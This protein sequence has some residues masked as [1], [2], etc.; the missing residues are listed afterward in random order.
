MT[1]SQGSCSRTSY[2]G[3]NFSPTPDAVLSFKLLHYLSKAPGSFSQTMWTHAAIKPNCL[4]I[5]P[6][7]IVPISYDADD[8]HDGDD[9]VDII[10][11]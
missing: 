6:L 4:T 2:T 9:E 3:F 11:E 10:K 5:S 7:C 8:D 1:S